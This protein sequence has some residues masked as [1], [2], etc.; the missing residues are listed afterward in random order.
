MHGR[1]LGKLARKLGKLGKLAAETGG[2]WRNRP[3]ETGETG[4]K[5]QRKLAGNWG[6]WPSDWPC[7]LLNSCLGQ[8]LQVVLAIG[9]VAR[10]VQG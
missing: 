3:A 5:I 1:K 8:D 10:V 2:N 9:F 6:N 7:C 4:H